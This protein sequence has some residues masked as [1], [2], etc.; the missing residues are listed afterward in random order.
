MNTPP[1]MHGLPLVLPCLC[2]LVVMLLIW[3]RPLLVCPRGVCLVKGSILA[4]R[5]LVVGLHEAKS[6]YI[7]LLC[8]FTHVG[9]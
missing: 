7:A 4:I 9:P 5:V 1:K 8:L 2:W 3:D 6:V